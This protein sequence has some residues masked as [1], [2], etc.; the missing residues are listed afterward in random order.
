MVLSRQSLSEGKLPT[1]ACHPHAIQRNGLDIPATILLDGGARVVGSCLRCPDIP[2][3]RYT[4]HEM[5]NSY[6]PSFPGDTSTRVCPTDAI[7]MDAET[8]A[9]VVLGSKCICC[10]LCVARCAVHAI[11][12]ASQGAL[13]NDNEDECFRLT[14]R[15]V[16]SSS[17]ASAWARFSSVPVAGH[18]VGEHQRFAAHAYDRIMTV[19]LPSQAQFPNL[20]TRN[21]M[22]AVGVPFQ[23]RRLGDTNMRIDG[24]FQPGR[25]RIGVAEIE[26]S[27]MAILD[28]PRNVLD[29]CAV[30]KARHGFPLDRIDPLVVSLRLPNVRSEYWRVIQDI[31]NVLRMRIAS[32][33]VGVLLLLLWEGRLLGASSWQELYADSDSP[34][35]EP[36]LR[37]YL[38]AA[39]FDLCPDPA[40]VRAAK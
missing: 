18:M 4:T 19:G 15:S 31:S 40:W 2:C 30:L 37:K 16:S 5:A 3:Q 28:A 10:G 29:D 35:I 34:T 1:S 20:L 13:V 22:M 25:D 33:T 39:S 12:L 27:D 23:I 8:G 24:V 26:P 7:Q 6:F 38:M 36:A 21:L 11:G 9:P 17:V 14:G 32:I